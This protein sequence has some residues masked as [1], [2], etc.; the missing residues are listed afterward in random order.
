MK[1]IIHKFKDE[2]ALTLIMSIFSAAMLA[3]IELASIYQL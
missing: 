1:N 3:L 2:I